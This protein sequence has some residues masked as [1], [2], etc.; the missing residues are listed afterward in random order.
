MF[1]M[2][3][4]RLAQGLPEAMCPETADKK[5]W[6]SQQ[7]AAGIAEIGKLFPNIEYTPPS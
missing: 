6:Q 7:L 1:S 4:L 5:Y 2:L 3:S